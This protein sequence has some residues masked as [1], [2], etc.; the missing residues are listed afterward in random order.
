MVG[1]TSGAD[2]SIGNGLPRRQA[3]HRPAKA[4]PGAQA[5]KSCRRARRWPCGGVRLSG[6]RVWLGPGSEHGP[7]VGGADGVAHAMEEP[8]LRVIVLPAPA[9]V[10]LDEMGTPALCEVAPFLR[11]LSERV[12]GFPFRHERP[13]RRR[14]RQAY[15]PVISRSRNP[16]VM[17]RTGCARIP[18]ENTRR[19]AA[20][21]RPEND[22][23]AAGSF[24]VAPKTDPPGRGNP[25]GSQIGAGDR[26]GVSADRGC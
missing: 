4:P 9:V 26:G 5:I 13:Q 18:H 10:E 24:A 2:G 17:L 23:V 1:G 20:L 14:I 8:L 7:G 11:D 19:F 21:A 16:P 15:G 6:W 22:T 25:G 3:I 12:R